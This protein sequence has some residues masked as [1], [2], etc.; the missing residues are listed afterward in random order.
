M[1]A[2][3]TFDRAAGRVLHAHETN[4]SGRD[5]AAGELVL[6]RAELTPVGAD[7]RSVLEEPRRLS[8]Q[9]PDIVDRVADRDDET[10]GRLRVAVG[11]DR[12]NPALLLVPSEDRLAARVAQAVGGEPY[13]EPD[14]AVERAVLVEQEPGQLLLEEQG[15][16]VREDLL[17]DALGRDK[18]LRL[19]RGKCLGPVGPILS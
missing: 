10:G 14:R 2:P 11:I 19:P 16:Y 12:H 7:A 5:A 18:S 17:L 6:R 13:V 3:A 15:L 8:H 9:L 1:P 4:G